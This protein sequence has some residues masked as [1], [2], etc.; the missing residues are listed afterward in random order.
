ML[1]FSALLVVSPI[2]SNLG[3]AW[4]EFSRAPAARL[5][6]TNVEVGTLGY[7][8]QRARLDFWLRRTVTR[9]INQ[10][11]Q[12]V[13]TDTRT[14]ARARPLLASIRDIPVPKFAPIGSSKGPPVILDGIGYSLKTYSDDGMLTEGT[15]IGTPL[16]EWIE[17]ALKTLEPCWGTRV[18]ERTR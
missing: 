14:C 1:V 9:G 15:N 2:P 11:E 13:W 18:P 12:I 10:E 7:D 6:K 8:R 5:T 4:A 3:P 17:A 16:A